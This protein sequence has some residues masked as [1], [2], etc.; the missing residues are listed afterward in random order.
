M[1]LDLVS[2]T[3]IIHHLSISVPLSNVQRRLAICLMNFVFDRQE[4]LNFINHDNL[5]DE[6]D[7]DAEDIF[8]D[9]SQ[10]MAAHGVPENFINPQDEKGH[11]FNFE[12]LHDI[13]ANARITF[14]HSTDKA[15]LLAQ[16]DD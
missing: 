1:T 14:H 8:S 3:L 10:K 16:F 9:F 7:M 15:V 4:I 6:R 5:L 11:Y 13:D 12:F 2:S